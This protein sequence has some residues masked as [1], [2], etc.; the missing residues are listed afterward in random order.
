MLQAVKQFLNIFKQQQQQSLPETFEGKVQ[1]YN[2]TR[3]KEL[4]KSFCFAPSVNMLFS[5]DGEVHACCHNLD[6]SLGRYPELSISEIWQSAQAHELRRQMA[7]FDLSKGCSI[8]RADLETG[9]FQEIRA[10][11]FDRVPQHAQYPTMMEFLLTNTCNLECVM[12]K[13]EYSSLIRQNR[14]KLPPIASPYD[15]RFLDQL[16]E[17]IPHLHETRFSGSG[18]AFAIDMN[19]RIWDM[20][21]EANPNCI[22]MV[23]TNGTFL[24][25]RI[26]DYLERGNFQ[27]GVSLDSLKKDVYESIRV[28]AK[29]EKVLQNIEYFSEYCRQRNQ[30]FVLAM[31]VM[32]ENWSELPDFVN[33]A[34]RMDAVV[35]FHKVWFPV[36]NALHNLSSEK[37][38]EIYDY[39]SSR[40]VNEE[41]LHG[42]WNRRH[43]KYMVSVI[44]QWLDQSLELGAEGRLIDTLHESELLPYFEKKLRQQLGYEDLTEERRKEMQ[45]YMAKVKAVVDYPGLPADRLTILKT[46]CLVP[47]AELEQPLKGKTVEELIADLSMF[48]NQ[49]AAAQA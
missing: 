41:G 36:E 5:Q 1:A 30:K 46:I 15:E 12:C 13:G 29:F 20:L 4:R 48:V 25:A 49:N 32:R 19:Y 11:H 8:C 3:K 2:Q 34:N 17:F 26:K 27:I 47:P 40:D 21:L 44:K 43:F 18:E 9:N 45:V 35:N 7:N 31:C 16:K 28:H 24:N 37:L 42:K 23:Q 14:E 33:F 22:I 38:Q 39:L 10:G 6:Y